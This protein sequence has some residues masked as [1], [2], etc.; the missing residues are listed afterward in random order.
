MVVF[1]LSIST[2][3]YMLSGFFG[4]RPS[5]D[6][7]SSMPP[8]A[9]VLHSPRILRNH[10]TQYASPSPPSVNITLPDQQ[11]SKIKFL[12]VKTG[13]NQN[14]P[15]LLSSHITH[16][17]RIDPC[18]DQN[19]IRLKLSTII[20]LTPPQSLPCSLLR[21][22]IKRI[23][24][25]TSPYNPALCCIPSSRHLLLMNL[26]SHFQCWKY[27]SIPRGSVCECILGREIRAKILRGCDHHTPGENN[28]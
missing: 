6:I 3:H 20:H 17:L 1:L 21:S 7:S 18:K 9:P 19:I 10:H 2:S 15:S 28:Q 8:P 12:R 23:P 16:R 24:R 11:L 27:P 22:R 25:S 26:L 13:L 14:L 5:S 4:S